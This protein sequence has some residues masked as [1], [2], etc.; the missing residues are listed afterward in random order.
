[1]FPELTPNPI[2]IKNTC[3]IKAHLDNE[4]YAVVRVN[5]INL[6]EVK[7]LFCK[8][9]GEITGRAV[10]FPQLWNQSTEIPNSSHPGLMGEYGL[11]HGRAPWCVRTNKD[12]I[13]LYK[14][15][16]NANDVVCSMDAIGFSQDE[17]YLN[18]SHKL[19]FHVDQNPHVEPGCDFNS[20]QG[21]FYAEDSYGERAGTV[22]VP[23]SH[24]EWK[25][26]K[27]TNNSHFQIVDQDK[28][29]TKAVKLNI[30]AGCLLLFNSKLVHQGMYGPHR[31]CFMVCYGDKKDRTEKTRQHKVVMYLGGQRSSHWSQF[32]KYHGWKWQHGEPW[33]ILIPATM[34][35]YEEQ[36]DMIEDMVTDPGSYEPGM[37]DAVPQNRLALL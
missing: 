2:D 14:T 11:S 12:I 7:S 4:G 17:A 24:R 25:N 20:I 18:A 36:I 22:V 1:M 21:I 35:H 33:N 26:H 32:G 29:A 19:W 30:S 9:I 8:D 5:S 31:L 13:A 23:G 27:Y 3:E 28:Y 10:T 16:L 34:T 37:D 6:E 15:L